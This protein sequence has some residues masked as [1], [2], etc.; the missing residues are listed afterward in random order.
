MPAATDRIEF[1]PPPAPGRLS[2]LAL[3]VLA[4]VLLMLALTWGISWNREPQDLSAE[5]ELW[6]AVPQEAAPAPV[7]APPPQPVVQAPPLQP[8]APPPPPAPKVET[9]P[10]PPPKAPDINL[11]RQKRQQE[12]ARREQELER[13]QQL[14]A[15]KRQQ[16]LDRRKE[17]EAQRKREELERQKQLDARQKLEDDKRKLAEKKKSEEQAKAKAKQEQEAK[18]REAVRQQ[19]ID[20]MRNLASGTGGP[21][22]QGTAARSSGQSAS[23]AGRIRARVRPNIVFT[24][25][26]AGNPTA[27]VEVRMAPDGTIVGKR[28]L[29]SSGVPGWDDAVLRALEKTEVMPRDI[30][31]RVPPSMILTFRPKD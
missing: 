28:V 13:E 19:Q 22:S 12:Q 24:D 31:G 30:D 10:P 5:A 25:D 23:Y 6:S 18:L 7:P 16:E 8:P 14:E 2:A 15:R 1:V 9:P 11:E 3:A 21:S 17:L 26:V 20:R 29:K 4:H 27:E